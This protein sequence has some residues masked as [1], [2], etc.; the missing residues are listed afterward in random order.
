M[1]ELV[2]EAACVALHAEVPQPKAANGLA[3]VPLKVP[4]LLHPDRFRLD[5]HEPKVVLLLMGELQLAA[6]HQ[7]IAGPS[8]TSS[9]MGAPASSSSSSSS[10]DQSNWTLQ[11]SLEVEGEVVVRHCYA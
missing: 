7:H 3:E 8:S 5:V 9:S 1:I 11:A 2:E 4:R 10:S 6:M